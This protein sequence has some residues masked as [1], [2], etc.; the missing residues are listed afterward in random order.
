MSLFA[1]LKD[2]KLKSLKFGET[3]T[4]GDST[5]P[6]IVTDINTVDRAFNRLRLSKFDD[7]FI[8]GGAIGSTNAGVTDAIRIGKFFTD[9]PVGP[10]FLTKQVALQLSN[11]RLEI[12]Q[13]LGNTVPSP[14]GLI[15]KIT[16]F[17]QNI[18][19]KINNATGGPTR[20][21]NLGINTLAQ[22]PVNAL[23]QHIVRHGFSPTLDDEQK[24]ESI[25]TANNNEKDNRLAKLYNKF[26]LGRLGSIQT[27]KAKLQ[28]KQVK[29]RIGGILT[30]ATSFL[31]SV[32]A[33]SNLLGGSP[34]LSQLSNTVSKINNVTSPPANMI[35]DQYTGGPNSRF[36]VGS[37][38]IR[39]TTITS[40][41][42]KDKTLNDL[43][44]TRIYPTEVRDL[45]TADSGVTDM[46]RNAVKASPISAADK[47]KLDI[48]WP[49]FY[50]KEYKNSV[51]NIAINNQGVKQLGD[52]IDKNNDIADATI[53]YYGGAAVDVLQKKTNYSYKVF[54]LPI[55]KSEDKGLKR[56]NKNFKYFNEYG[57]LDAYERNDGENMSVVF[58]LINPF[59]AQNLHRVIFPAYIN[60]FKV[61]S[62]AT[63]GDVSYIGR[64]E[65][66]YV[67]NKFKRSVSFSL[68]I[69]CFNPVELRERH[70]A[71]GALES[72]LAG[73][74][75]PTT[76]NPAGGKAISG[77]KLGGILTKLYLG[78]YL[79]GEIG[80]I[81]SLS[82]DIPNDSSW[83]L[84]DQLAHN[85]N[86]SVNFTVIHNELP[87][88][89]KEGGFFNKNIKNAANYF[90]STE[91]ALNNTG[92][93][94]DKDLAS[95]TEFTE[96]TRNSN[97]TMYGPRIDKYGVVNDIKSRAIQKLPVTGLENKLS[98]ITGNLFNR[99]IDLRDPKLLDKSI[100]LTNPNAISKD[101]LKI[102]PFAV[103][104]P[105]F[106]M[107][108]GIKL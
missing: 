15:G 100:D 86:V 89:V 59:T 88:Y 28:D 56:G 45:I 53:T 91:D 79:R 108:K 34:F 47:S 63:W 41:S 9:L 71:L 42:D 92:A 40:N 69:P 8:R 67:F 30:S 10:L 5:K 51:Y 2:T 74:Y 19:T 11:P 35:I 103:P 62:D 37:T 17:V 44:L 1:K 31:G 87:T 6:Y 106:D 48:P 13:G 94:S 54:G 25:V 61:S 22:I 98:I 72:S 33:I 64:S 14:P 80:I 66:F 60:G 36:G 57:K 102:G 46:Y 27:K 82:Y 23:G 26:Q 90:I 104:T 96:V 97:G 12:R 16:S 58:Q 70:R 78:N 77:N 29:D 21:Y 3:G 65:N 85:I 32:N 4:K 18:G 39:R 107:F 49:G 99:P 50:P 52:I 55:Q 84:D 93:N 95:F 73:M 43:A 20:T 7:G 68:Q 75:G 38:T 101:S 76:L 83:D 81:N 105:T 24:Y